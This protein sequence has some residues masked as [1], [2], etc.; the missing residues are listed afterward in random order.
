MPIEIVE[1]TDEKFRDL[2][3]RG[4]GHFLDFKSK[5]ITPAKLTRSLSAFS[6]ADGGELYVGIEDGSTVDTRRWVGFSEIEGANGFIQTFEEFFPL[7]SYFR[8]EFVR[9]ASLPGLILHCEVSKTPDVRSSSDGKVYLRRGAQNLRQDTDEK[10]SRLQLNKGI[11][12][13]EDH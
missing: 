2:L 7:G 5:R 11:T 6:N 9:C 10:L 8:Y 4:E 12:S 13:Y 3:G 1:I